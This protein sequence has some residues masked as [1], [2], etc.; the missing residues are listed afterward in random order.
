[1]KPVPVP[2]SKYPPTDASKKKFSFVY[3]MLIT[4][5]PLVIRQRLIMLTACGYLIFSMNQEPNYVVIPKT[6]ITVV[7]CRP[8]YTTDLSRAYVAKNGKKK[9]VS[10][11]A[12]TSVNEASTALL[13]MNARRGT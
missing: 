13:F 10:I 11:H 7:I 4:K 2:M 9:V 12:I 1:M 8:T 6:S 5:H 3:S